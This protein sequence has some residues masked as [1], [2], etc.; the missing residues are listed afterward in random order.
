MIGV[1][2]VYNSALRKFD[3]RGRWSVSPKNKGRSKKTVVWQWVPT[4]KEAVP[5]LGYRVNQRLS[6]RSNGC[7]HACCRMTGAPCWPVGGGDGGCSTPYQPQL[8]EILTF[9]EK[10]LCFYSISFPC[11]SLRGGI[12]GGGGH[13]LF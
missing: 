6:Q 13:W 9:F 3:F 12:G 10:R 8:P 1:P 4:F 2:F 7:P 5:P 11:F